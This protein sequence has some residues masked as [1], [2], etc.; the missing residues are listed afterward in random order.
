MVTDIKQ[1]ILKII[2]EVYCAE[3]I[4]TLDVTLLSPGY[5]VKLNMNE[6]PISIGA[7]L[8]YDKFLKFFRK[9]IESRNFPNYVKYFKGIKSYPEHC[10]VDRKCIKCND[11]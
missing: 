1:D 7:E 11:R 4:G 9:E 8:E 3:Y 2:R 5:I 10:P 6:N